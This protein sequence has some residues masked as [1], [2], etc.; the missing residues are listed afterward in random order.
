MQPSCIF[1]LTRCVNFGRSRWRHELALH[2]AAACSHVAL[3]ERLPSGSSSFGGGFRK[4]ELP[5]ELSH[6][7]SSCLSARHTSSMGCAI[8]ELWISH[9]YGASLYQ[10]LGLRLFK[11]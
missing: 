3:L 10:G 9:H 1:S 6:V 2:H 11:G 5:A 7:A 4:R 8:V